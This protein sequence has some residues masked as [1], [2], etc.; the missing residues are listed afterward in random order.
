MNLHFSFLL[1]LIFSVAGYAQEKQNK[2]YN[3]FFN[4]EKPKRRYDYFD[5]SPQF[6]LPNPEAP[7]LTD[8]LVKRRRYITG[9]DIS[10]KDF[11]D[12]FNMPV[13]RPGPE[14]SSNMPVMVPDSSVH[15]FILKVRPGNQGILSGP[16][17]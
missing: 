3:K 10:E 6:K 7:V 11:P 15:Y 8:S 5:I 9:A 16:N 13:W 17:K 1:V 12:Y 4:E 2:P 14:F